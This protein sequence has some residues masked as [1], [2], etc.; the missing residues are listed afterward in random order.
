[1]EQVSPGVRTPATLFLILQPEKGTFRLR[2]V[3]V[4]SPS[5]SDV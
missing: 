2:R 4:V 1:M 3:I 5:L